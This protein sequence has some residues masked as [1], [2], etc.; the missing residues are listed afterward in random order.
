MNVSANSLHCSS[1][2]LE[3]KESETLKKN[4]DLAKEIKENKKAVKYEYGNRRKF[5]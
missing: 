4:L 3:I 1:K 5:S 2:S